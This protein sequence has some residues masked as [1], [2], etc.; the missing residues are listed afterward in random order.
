MINAEQ[1]RAARALLDWSTADL[2]KL[3]GLTVNGIN[4][5]ERSHTQPHVSTAAL[6]QK[7]FEDTGIEFLPNSGLRRKNRIT[8]TYEGAEALQK[9]LDR[10]YAK[11]RDTGDELLIVHLDETMAI[12]SLN[13]DF[14]FD[15]IQKRK[16]ANITCRYLVNALPPETMPADL[17]QYR[18]MPA[19]SFSPYPFY[20]FGSTLA[21]ISWLPAPQIII[22]DD[23]RFATSAR[24]LFDFVW[25]K[26]P[27]LQGQSP[28]DRGA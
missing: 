6:I 27:P 23:Q 3:T 11:L 12:E 7:I 9:L 26:C 8:E 28:D 19:E 10:I 20:I 24:K 1:I 15:H 17:S 4:K 16:A 13:A 5:I 25:D 14:L 18:V 2:A 21:L 22:I